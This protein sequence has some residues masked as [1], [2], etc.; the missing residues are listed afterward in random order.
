MSDPTRINIETDPREK[1]MRGTSA[2]GLID[3]DVPYV[4]AV[5]PNLWQGGCER[6]LKLPGEIK[7]LVSLY[8]WER[9]RI[10]GLMR[11]ELYV[12]MYDSEDQGYEQVDHI[13][14]W[15]NDCRD[16]GPV[17]VHCQAGLNRSA[18]V[19]ARALHLR[20]GGPGTEIVDRLRELRSPAVL[21]NPAFA[22]E[23]KSWA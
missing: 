22:A 12:E 20:E 14:R 13:A 15:V 2:H 23:V 8:P 5:A 16:D 9:Y 17:L 21:C 19:V 11:S 7:H 10:D 18:L 3:F 1:R 6:G 4:T